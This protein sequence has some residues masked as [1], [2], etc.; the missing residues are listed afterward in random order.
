MLAN[1]P[2]NSAS[3]EVSS[4]PAAA[5]ESGDTRADELTQGLLRLQE[6]HA[7]AEEEA[8]A[9][10]QALEETLRGA[11]EAR[12]QSISPSI[13]IESPRPPRAAEAIFLDRKVMNSGRGVVLPPR[14]TNTPRNCLAVGKR[15]TDCICK[16]RN[17]LVK[18][19]V[20]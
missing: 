15:P 13:T 14:G 11:Q 12:S 19:L 17:N 6:A 20:P 18:N 5:G 7:T 10:Q 2:Q 16:Y 8:R 1:A 9:R 4:A 3:G